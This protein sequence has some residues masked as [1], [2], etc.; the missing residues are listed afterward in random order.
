MRRIGVQTLE[1]AHRIEKVIFSAVLSVWDKGMLCLPIPLQT[2]S[3]GHRNPKNPFSPSHSNEK[4][5]P[6]NKS[7]Q[8]APFGQGWDPLLL[9]LPL[10]SS[11]WAFPEEYQ[12]LTAE[13]FSPEPAKLGL[14]DADPWGFSSGKFLCPPP[15]LSQQL[16]SDFSAFKHIMCS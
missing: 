15:S 12:G 8:A 3:P 10:T 13:S 5:S 1:R 16:P 7:H 9:S 4:F 2:L 6:P 14:A 11:P